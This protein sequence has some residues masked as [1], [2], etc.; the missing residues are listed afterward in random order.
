LLE[1]PPNNDTT[2]SEEAMRAL[3]WVVMAGA[4]SVACA[5]GSMT[6]PSPIS[7]K[8]APTEATANRYE[9]IFSRPF[10]GPSRVG[11][12]FDHDLPLATAANGYVLTLCG[13]RDSSQVDGHDGYDYQLPEGTPLLAVAD[14]TV[15]F[16]GLESPRACPQLGRT[17][18]ALV[19]ATV[20]L[21]SSGDEFAVI[22][23]HLSRIDAAT[24]ATVTS[25]TPV[26]LSGN[27]GCSGTPHLHFGVSRKV[28]GE[29]RLL[30]PYGWHAS[31]VDPWE[32]HAVGTTSTWLWKPGE[33]P[34]LR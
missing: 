14:G 34:A 9:P 13:D 26:G 3:A 2:Q 16:A 8:C 24:G 7:V 11:N 23:G 22:Y 27:K 6:T 18:Q 19:V 1:T 33:A 25:R 30:D 10:D 32:R 17:V 28:S 5:C 4:G 31:A 21:T 29:Y 15:L 20:H 12:D